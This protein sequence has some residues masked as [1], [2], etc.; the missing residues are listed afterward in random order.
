MNLK[1]LSQSNW[2]KRNKEKVRG[3]KKKWRDKNPDYNQEYQKK[4]QKKYQKEWYRDNKEKKIK[5]VVIYQKK[6]R[7]KDIRFRLDNNMRGDIRRALK[8][9]KAGRKWESLVG[10]TV[11]DL[12]KHLEAQFDNKTNWNNYGSYWSIDHKKPKSL[13]SYILPEDK[14]FKECWALSNLQPMEKIANIK[15]G[16]K[17][18]RKENY[19]VKSEREA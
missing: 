3:Y 18:F 14:E 15:K 17:F 7:Q 1:Y 16:N 11:I 13:F 4:Y 2:A 12:M 19:C 8:G 5:Q 9:K 6:R 10:Y